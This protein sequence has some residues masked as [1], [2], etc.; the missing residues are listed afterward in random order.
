MPLSMPLG[1][2]EEPFRNFGRL[3]GGFFPS[4][5][6]DEALSD[7][8]QRGVHFHQAWRAVEHRYRLCADCSDEF[9]AQIVGA[10]ALWR[11]WSMDEEVNYAVE[12]CIYV[13][14]V[15]G[16]SV[17]ESFG[18]GLYF[19]GHCLKPDEFPHV[20]KP[21]RISLAA[22]SKAFKV[23]FPRAAI[24]H[25]LEELLSSPE[26]TT[27]D[28][29][30]N[31]LAHRLSGKRNIR[32]W[33]TTHPDGTHTHTR[34]EAWHLPGLDNEVVFDDGLIQRHMDEITRLLAVLVLAAL[35]F[36]GEHRLGGAPS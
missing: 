17:F 32:S 12:R 20:S 30:R 7:P 3:A 1:F 2:P 36:V 8:L 22:T 34:E 27:I 18:F 5:I 23:A 16:L 19:L 29:I 11:E 15:S 31:I 35:E 14:F 6:S 21:R 4:S 33:G 24:T 13:F 9:K 10:S 28:G 26:F 25:H